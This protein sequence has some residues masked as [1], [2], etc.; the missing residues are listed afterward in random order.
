MYGFALGLDFWETIFAVITGGFSSFFFFYFITDLFL[1]Y[2]RHLKPVVVFVTPHRTRLRYRNWR[3]RRQEKV[4]NKRTFTRRNKFFVRMRIS[5]GMWGIIVLT[6]V[7]LSIPV[8]AFLLRKYYGHRK[9]AVPSALVAL[10]LEGLL[11]ATVF[12]M[13]FE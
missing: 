4:K 13:I 5:Y 7:A 3:T 2:V 8:G 11:T 6:P 10:A 1:V 9:E 12:W